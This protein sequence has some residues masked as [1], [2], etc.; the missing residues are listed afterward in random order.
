VLQAPAPVIAQLLGELLPL[1]G[2]YVHSAAQRS[3]RDGWFNVI[4]KLLTAMRE[5]DSYRANAGRTP[6]IG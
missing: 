4:T 3:R 6:G 1:D 2:A 5:F